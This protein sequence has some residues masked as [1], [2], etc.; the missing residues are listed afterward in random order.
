MNLV[1]NSS[2]RTAGET[3]FTTDA[4][5]KGTT[6]SHAL[7][8]GTTLDLVDDADCGTGQEDGFY[9]R[10]FVIAAWICTRYVS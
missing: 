3:T 1:T 5:R 9:N 7:V 2:M 4:L 8:S 6:A 10:E